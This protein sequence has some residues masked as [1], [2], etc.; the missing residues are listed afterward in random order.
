ME[1]AIE[2]VLEEVRERLRL[3]AGGI[4]LVGVDKEAGEVHVRFEGTCR[5]CPLSAMTLKHGVEAALKERLPWCQRVI[6]V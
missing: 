1:S 6:A 5:H 3:H 2:A 4:Q